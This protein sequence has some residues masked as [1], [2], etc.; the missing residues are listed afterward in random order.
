MNFDF[1][2]LETDRTTLASLDMQQVAEKYRAWR[3]IHC[4]NVFL[5]GIGQALEANP[6]IRCVRVHF[7]H[8][9]RSLRDSVSIECD[10]N[11]QSNA[12]D[13]IMGRA[14]KKIG[15]DTSTWGDV[16]YFFGI[17]A[18]HAMSRDDF[19]AALPR[20]LAH[21][22]KPFGPAGIQAAILDATTT[23]TTHRH[24]PGRL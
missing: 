16:G 11:K 23:T 6:A 17:G 14:R 19:L 21:D 18:T 1:D 13:K 20:L 8:D 10:D 24:R 5:D 4:R 2:T 3:A 15:Q 7:S 22:A 12:F 9:K